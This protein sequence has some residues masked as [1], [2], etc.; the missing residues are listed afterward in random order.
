MSS[1]VSGSAIGALLAVSMLGCQR[2]P[3]T[4]EELRLLTPEQEEKLLAQAERVETGNPE[5]QPLTDS[6]GAVIGTVSSSTTVIYLKRSAGG[7]RFS[8]STTCTSTCAG[9]P[10]NLDPGK[11]TNSCGCNDKCDS[12]TGPVDSAGC[13]GSCS[14][15]KLGFGNFG[16]F[17]M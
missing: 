17:A 12:C 15:T 3:P 10:I 6:K 11:P 4:V 9:S 8:V 2:R 16:I 14:L 5:K 1:R 7:G 13:T